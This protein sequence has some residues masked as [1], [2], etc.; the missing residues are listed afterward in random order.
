M[1]YS[2]ECT[3]RLINK[4]AFP[5]SHFQS[6][7]EGLFSEERPRVRGLSPSLWPLPCEDRGDS[8]RPDT[9]AA[10]WTLPLIE[11]RGTRPSLC[12]EYTTKW[13]GWGVC[14]VICQE[15]AVGSE[16]K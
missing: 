11:F 9:T 12:D 4:L 14:L 7:E 10:L 2:L 16:G 15:D 5:G 6:G 13:D 8:L 3:R 1:D